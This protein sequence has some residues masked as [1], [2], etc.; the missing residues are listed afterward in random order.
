MPVQ[1]VVDNENISR[2]KSIYDSLTSNVIIPE[3]TSNVSGS[4]SKLEHYSYSDDRTW[5]L[6]QLL[7]K[8]FSH[9]VMCCSH[10]IR[11]LYTNRMGYTT[12]LCSTITCRL[13]YRT[14]WNLFCGLPPLSSKRNDW[15]QGR[16]T[17][18]GLLSSPL[19]IPTIKL[20]LRLP[21]FSWVYCL[22]YI[23]CF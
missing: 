23:S 1:Q 9:N 6:L 16:L 18:F 8:T 12:L 3:W 19:L 4:T 15:T 13:F 11:N 21:T 14:A 20:H 2:M 10:G 5:H 17:A 7:F 22:Y